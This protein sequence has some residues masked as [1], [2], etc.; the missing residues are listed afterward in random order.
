DSEK[1]KLTRL[2][3]AEWTRTRRKVKAAAADMAQQLIQLYA[4]RQ[5]ARGFA[6]PEDND[7]QRDFE[8]R[9]EYDETQDQLTATE[10]I[11]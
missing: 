5:Q 2:G 11:K 6:F 3:G 9:F 10:E 4:R 8:T 7:W 1:V